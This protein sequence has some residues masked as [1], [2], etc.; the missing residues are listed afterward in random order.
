M[1]TTT[2]LDGRGPLYRQ[3]ARAVGAALRAGGAGGR[4]LATRELAERLGVSR[5]TVRA[6]YELLAADGLLVAQR[7][8]G[9]FAA[10]PAAP[11]ENVA[12]AAATSPQSA[13][14]SRCRQAA[15]AALSLGRLHHG[16]RF[17]L[18]YGEPAT[19]VLFSDVW[20]RELSTAAKLTALEYPDSHGL[21]A[22]REAICQ[23]LWHRR[24]LRAAPD[25]VLVLSGTQQALSLA[26]RVLL[27][28]G[29]RVVL[30]NPCYFFAREVMQA[31]GAR[32]VPVDVD[33][34]GLLTTRLPARG[35]ALVCV[36]PSHQFP[37]G[38]VLA[39]HRRAELLAYARR[40]DAWVLEDDYDAEFRY[41]GRR[42]P[43]LRAD[44]ADD[45]VIHVGS[46][47]KTLAPALRLGF[48]VMP[49]ALRSDFIMAKRLADLGN[50]AIEQA[51]LAHLLTSG[52]FERHMRR[53][54]NTLTH[55]RMALMA[56]L[57]RHGGERLRVVDSG[58]GMHLLAL[59][60]HTTEAQESR[61]IDAARQVGIGLHP[62]SAHYLGA[63]RPRGL[64]LGYAG[65]APAQIDAACKALG[66][67]IS[68]L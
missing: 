63:R 20:R 32:I 48:L 28:E 44:D 2:D 46:F 27:D 47:S 10:A 9:S 50:P 55:R 62:L 51:A 11:P 58:A 42:V 39:P 57:A 68:A 4:L 17:N 18:Q 19:D 23:H 65:L 49:R 29:D 59:M 41:D 25:D 1:I 61:L 37:L 34:L 3:L 43:P 22:L 54:M 53:V 8:A 52:A 5:N 40:H 14:A 35:A 67:C 26:A 30:E 66:R 64:L 56:G 12:R 60:P 36:T 21:K 33:R 15:N 45:R 13:F 24:G 38:V 31:H 6:A 7:G 16:L